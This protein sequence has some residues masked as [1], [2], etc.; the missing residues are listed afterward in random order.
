MFEGVVPVLHGARV[1]VELVRA[2]GAPPRPRV[3]EVVPGLE[4][5]LARLV[6]LAVELP[7]GVREARETLSG[8]SCPGR[9]M[10]GAGFQI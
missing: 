8:I 10:R 1:L 9:L 4:A 2:A 6:E 7:L 5:E 3:L